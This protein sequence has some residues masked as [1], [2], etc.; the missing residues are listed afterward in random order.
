MNFPID[1]STLARAKTNRTWRMTADN[2]NLKVTPTAS[3]V[4]DAVS[5]MK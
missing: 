1:F 2:H 3:T 5:F 4:L